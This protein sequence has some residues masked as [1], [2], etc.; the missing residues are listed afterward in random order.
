MG[1]KNNKRIKVL[2]GNTSDIQGGAARAA[3]RLNRALNKLKVDSKMLVQSK[4]GDDKNVKSVAETKIQKGLA[5]I[6]PYYEVLLLELYKNR[7]KGPF[8][9]ARTGVDICK[10]EYV[11]EADLINLHWINAGFLSLKSIRKLN[12]LHKPI[13]WTLHDMWPF[14]GG[15]HYSGGCAKYK[16]KCGKC[17]ILNSSKDRDLTRRI[18]EKKN[19]YYKNLNLTIVTCSTWLAQCAKDSSLFNDL[20][21]EVIPNSVDINV[22]KPIKK[23]IARGILNLHQNKYLLLFGA[24]S[25]TSDKRKGFDYLNKALNKIKATYPEL[26]DKIELIIFGASYSEDIEI[27]PFKTHFL[28]RLTDEHG[29]A[30]CYSSADVFITPSLEDNLPNTIME[31]LSCGTPVVGFKTGGI[32]DMIK[33]KQ[34]GYLAEYKSVDDLAQGICWML[35]DKSRLI[36]LEQN[37]RQKVLDNYTYDIVGNK[38][39]ELYKELLNEYQ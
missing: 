37:A 20:R 9:V 39:L 27:L 31:S 4:A 35:E 28:G 19:K 17:P 10:N 22:F 3:F 21:I 1:E 29:L 5:K 2:H 8:S 6:R 24:M 11:K 36:D 23:K 34:N 25:A 30:L 7:Q 16:E 26:E 15:C 14:T 38:Y 13:V 32:P 33:H 12:Q 18:W